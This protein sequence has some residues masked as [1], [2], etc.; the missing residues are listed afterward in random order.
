MLC[1]SS[2]LL[3]ITHTNIILILHDF[4]FY[5][6]RGPVDILVPPND[7]DNLL[8]TLERMG[9]SSNVIIENIQELIDKEAEA[10]KKAN[11]KGIN[12]RVI[13]HMEWDR[14]YDIFDALGYVDYLASECSIVVYLQCLSINLVGILNGST[15]SYY[16]VY[17]H[18]PLGY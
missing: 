3:N 8:D 18:L 12:N 5:K 7:K 16:K 1:I 15:I 2:W 13:D 11:A 14:Y 4:K 10:L 6:T 17:F 9:I